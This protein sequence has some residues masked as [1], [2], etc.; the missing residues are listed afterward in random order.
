MS[1]G[2]GGQA[3]A[4]AGRVCG[5]VLAAR[6]K[7]LQPT[8]RVAT[9]AHAAPAAP[10]RVAP[11]AVCYSEPGDCRPRRWART[12]LSNTR[13]LLGGRLGGLVCAASAAAQRAARLCVTVA[14]ADLAVGGAHRVVGVCGA[15][16]HRLQIAR[17]VAQAGTSGHGRH[18]RHRWTARWAGDMELPL[19][20]A[21]GVRHT[22]KAVAT[23]V[24]CSRC[25]RGSTALFTHMV[26]QQ[27]LLRSAWVTYPS[28]RAAASRSWAPD[29]PC[30]RSL[31]STL[32]LSASTRP[33]VTHAAWPQ[34]QD[35]RLM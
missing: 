17:A 9:A 16:H 15:A 23:E 24:D 12:W 31:A 7:T 2:A 33:S 30:A 13:G 28:L 27:A 32:P 4:Q 34:A 25:Q 29:R 20:C 8:K 21:A 19:V 6:R 11:H 22:H 5:A 18:V 10:S 1:D 3:S 26:T 14:G 35:L